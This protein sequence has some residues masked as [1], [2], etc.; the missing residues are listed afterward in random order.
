MVGH[1]LRFLVLFRAISAPQNGPDSPPFSPLFL[2]FLFFDYT[3]Y[4]NLKSHPRHRQKITPLHVR[5]S[6]S[7]NPLRKS[8]LT[9]VTRFTGTAFSFI[10]KNQEIDPKVHFSN[11]HHLLSRCSI[12]CW[13][14]PLFR[15]TAKHHQP[16]CKTSTRT[17]AHTQPHNT[18]L[19][20][21]HIPLHNPFAHVCV[22]T[23]AY[24]FKQQQKEGSGSIQD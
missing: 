8:S 20:C 9:P 4:P 19:L 18:F 21:Q 13:Y 10:L 5:F 17:H 22:I 16:F 6:S 12:N 14:Y 23:I 1:P 3:L 15:T 24:C 2:F 7:P 11:H